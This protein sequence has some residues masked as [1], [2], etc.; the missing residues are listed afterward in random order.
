V[1]RRPRI[2]RKRIATVLTA[3]AGVDL[4][5]GFAGFAL[6]ALLLERGE[7]GGRD[8]GGLGGFGLGAGFR[9]RFTLRHAGLANGFELGGATLF[10]MDEIWIGNGRLGL[11]LFKQS[12]LGRSC[13]FQAVGEF[14]FF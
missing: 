8:S 1:R 4:L 10:A 2:G 11:E 9:D 6:L 5:G 14:R 7:F 3:D 12:L 13:R